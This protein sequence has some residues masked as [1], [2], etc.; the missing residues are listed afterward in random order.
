METMDIDTWLLITVALIAG[1]LLALVVIAA[2]VWWRLRTSDQK[3]LA[4][5]IAKLR[6]RDKLSLAATL[7]RDPRVSLLPGAVAVALILY[8][9]MPIDIVPDFI[10]VLGYLDDVLILAIGAG[11]LLRSIPPQV[12]DEHVA[13]FEQAPAGTGAASHPEPPRELPSGG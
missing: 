5:R 9:V 13:R 11:L 4:K 1:S 2:F 6:F 3:R 7:F 12:L 10:P 8:L